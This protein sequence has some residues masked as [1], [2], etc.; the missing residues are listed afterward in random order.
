[1]I[2]ILALVTSGT[3]SYVPA[4]CRGCVLGVKAVWQ[5]NSVTAA[6][7]V[8]VARNATAVN[9]VT[10]VSGDGLVVEDGVPDTT[11]KGLVFDPD[12]ATATEQVMKVTVSAGG[13]CLVLIEYDQFATIV[14]A[15]ALA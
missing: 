14:E 6:D 10:A 2:R 9:T 13:A 1:M 3:V 4:P 11:N 12:S 5:T 15:P 8:I 7:T